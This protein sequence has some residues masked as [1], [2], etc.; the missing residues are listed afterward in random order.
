VKNSFAHHGAD[1]R[2]QAGTIASAG[3]YANLH[4][5]LLCRYEIRRNL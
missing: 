2:I 4:F 3:Q 5:S 1:H